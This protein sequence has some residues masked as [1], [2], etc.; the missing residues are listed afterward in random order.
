MTCQTYYF[1]VFVF[2]Y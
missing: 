2:L 1:E